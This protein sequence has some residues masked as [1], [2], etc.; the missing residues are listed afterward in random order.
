MRTWPVGLVTTCVLLMTW[1][2]SVLSNVNV[3]RVLYIKNVSD[4]Q[5]YSQ[6]MKNPKS[7]DSLAC[8]GCLCI[9]SLKDILWM[10]LSCD[11]CRERKLN[12]RMICHGRRE[13]RRKER[14]VIRRRQ[15]AAFGCFG[16]GTW[17]RR[18]GPAAWL[19]RGSGHHPREHGS[20][21]SPF[22]CLAF[23]LTSV[24]VSFC[25]W[26]ALVSPILSPIW[27]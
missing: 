8:F 19:S 11:H 2:Y 16:S 5:I 24:F 26:A 27:I 3:N 23:L 7:G 1:K 10:S 4:A 6:L 12:P 21:L 13:G 9:C 17:A 14:K 20:V 15:A 25:L 22:L 18:R